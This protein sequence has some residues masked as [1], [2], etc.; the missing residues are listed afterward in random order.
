MTCLKTLNGKKNIA[1]RIFS[2]Q[3]NKLHKKIQL[4]AIILAFHHVR[5]LAPNPEASN[6]IRDH[7]AGQQPIGRT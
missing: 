3:V 6:P 5:V 7:V 4:T 1:N 2:V